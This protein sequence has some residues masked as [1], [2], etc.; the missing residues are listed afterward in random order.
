MT[1]SVPSVLRG[2][3]A[4]TPLAQGGQGRLYRAEDGRIAGK[5]WVAKQL[6]ADGLEPD[7]HP[8][9]VA[10]RLGLPGLPRLSEA[11][12]DGAS[13]WIIRDFV[14]GRTLERLRID[15][16]GPFTREVLIDLAAGVAS[17]LV[18]LHGAGLLLID[19]K[20][21]N[22]M[23]TPDGRV[24]LID[25]GSITRAHAKPDHASGTLGFSAPE[26][27]TG[28]TLMASADVYG[29]AATLCWLQTQH[30]SGPDVE[31]SALSGMAV[32]GPRGVRSLAAALASN[33][34]HRPTLSELLDALRSAPGTTC[35]GCGQSLSPDRKFCGHCGTEAVGQS[36]PTPPTSPPIPVRRLLP[37]TTVERPRMLAAAI[38]QRASKGP[39]TSPHLA[40]LWRLA[41]HLAITDGF[42]SLIALDRAHIDSYD[43]QR[44]AALRVLREFRGSGVLADEVGLGKTIE[45]GIVLNELLARDLAGRVLILTP[46]HLTAKWALELSTKFGD[47]SFVVCGGP[48]N[49]G[50]RRLI[51]SHQQAVRQWFERSH[52]SYLFDWDHIVKL[53]DRRRCVCACGCSNRTRGEFE[54]CDRCDGDSPGLK[55]GLPEYDVVIV[56]EAHHAYKVDGSLTRLGQLISGLHRRY[57]LLVTATPLRR[58]PRELFQLI[59]LVRPGE[60]RNMADF[61]ARIADPLMA[62]SGK[63]AAIGRL[64]A[65]LN[66][67]MVR[68]RRRDIRIDWPQKSVTRHAIPLTAE[69]RVLRETAL[70]R[71]RAAKG[72]NARQLAVAAHSSPEAASSLLRTIWSS[73]PEA[74]AGSKVG[75][76]LEIL[77]RRPGEQVVVFAESNETIDMIHR[78]VTSAGRQAIR[79]RGD[80]LMKMEAVRRFRS[81][82]GSVII[83]DRQLAEGSDLQFAHVLVVFDVPW[84]PFV[85]EQMVGRVYRIGQ[86][87]TVEIHA[88]VSDD[89]LDFHLFDL[90][91]NSLRMFDRQVGEL[92]AIL[93]ELDDDLDFADEVW[94]A[95]VSSHNAAE[96]HSRFAGLKSAID[97]ALQELIAEESFLREMGL[98]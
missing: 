70:E 3:Y 95:V 40:H 69:E 17:V 21:A 86:T 18:D 39:T 38:E 65:V 63:Q 4:L 46:P 81:T 8:E 52:A 61:E 41:E 37:K 91:Q 44:V 29:L 93:T 50:A 45:A 75:R 22:F 2:R 82:P 74:A 55:A 64:Q 53:A 83:A 25:A 30:P 78:A 23:R 66:R 11:F 62:G 56:D 28:A 36:I 43:H 96:L 31:E 16:G 60:F 19:V 79:Y 9:V 87:S 20:P 88:I 27:S 32:F 7:A 58:D 13:I 67:V 42:D 59:S 57:L 34:T 90:Y 54:K 1:A 15:Q 35:R 71:A 80:R 76:L 92:D 77:R 98:A 89:G 47:S 26:A 49:W 12:K 51:A 73:P 33:P 97:G 48:G 24:L 85:L 6:D 14:E 10:L 5:V 94:K 68:Q 72:T 84:N